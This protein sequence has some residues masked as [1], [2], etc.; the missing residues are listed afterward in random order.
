MVSK[1]DLYK[2]AAS[3]FRVR[4]TMKLAFRRNVRNKIF[5]KLDFLLD[6]LTSSD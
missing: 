6:I 2:M 1:G 3:H 4:E 5:F